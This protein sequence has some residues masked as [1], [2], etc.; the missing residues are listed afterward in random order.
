[1]I[2]LCVHIVVN[3]GKEKEA[4]ALFRQ[5]QAESRKE[6]GCILYQV[7]THRDDS[8]KFLVYEQYKDD[9]A[10]E[11]HRESAHFKKY[12]ADGVYT[13]IESRD[14]GLYEPI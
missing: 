5:L 1:M 4:A 13:M 6:P 7:H 14:V 3:E 9:A 2:A 10:I 8:R 11:A 12:A